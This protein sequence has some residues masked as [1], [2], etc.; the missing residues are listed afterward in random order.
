LSRENLFDYLFLLQKSTI[1]YSIMD[2]KRKRDDMPKNDS[3]EQK[4]QKIEK[5]SHFL[6]QTQVGINTDDS[7]THILHFDL[8]ID[9]NRDKPMMI[10]FDDPKGGNVYFDSTFSFFDVFDL[11]DDKLLS[12]QPK[13][14]N[15]TLYYTISEKEKEEEELS[16][17]LKKI[18]NFNKFDVS[19]YTKET[20]LLLP[21]PLIRSAI[22]EYMK[23]FN[24]KSVLLLS[25]GAGNYIL[26]TPKK[27]QGKI[28]G[29]NIEELNQKEDEPEREKLN[30]KEKNKSHLLNDLKA[31]ETP[32][33]ILE[34][35]LEVL[36]MDT[37]MALVN[38]ELSDRVM[39][40][41]V[42]KNIKDAISSRYRI[43]SDT[44]LFTLISHTLEY[45]AHHQAKSRG[46]FVAN[47]IYEDEDKFKAIQYH[48]NKFS[49][50]ELKDFTLYATYG[51]EDVDE[52][53]RLGDTNIKNIFAYINKVISESELNKPLSY[54]VQNKELFKEMVGRK[55]NIEDVV[56]FDP[57]IGSGKGMIEAFEKVGLE[58][59]FKFYG[60]DL[61]KTL[62]VPDKY[63][64]KMAIIGGINTATMYSQLENINFAKTNH[65]ATGTMNVFTNPPFSNDDDIAKKTLDL[66]RNN[67]VISGV[68][69]LKMR[70]YIKSTMGQDS[71]IVEIP[72]HLSGYTDDSV[73]ERLLFFMGKKYSAKAKAKED[74]DILSDNLFAD[75]ST[76]GGMITEASLPNDATHEML[77]EALLKH[78]S[79]K[80]HY[81]G[82]KTLH[83]GEYFMNRDFKKENLILK[84][85][86]KVRDSME[87]LFQNASKF[88]A[89]IQ[90]ENTLKEFE[91]KVQP[92]E[93]AKN[94][95]VFLDTRYFSEKGDYN[96]LSF[97]EVVGDA[98]LLIHYAK[99]S[100]R[101]LDI[102]EVVA[103][104]KKVTLPID[105]NTINTEKFK[106][107]Q[108][109]SGE[110]D[111]VATDKLGLM[112]FAYYPT[113][114]DGRDKQ[115]R[116]NL[117]KVIQS[118]Y[119]DKGRTVTQE[120]LD[121]VDKAL[122]NSNS[123]SIR[124]LKGVSIDSE[125]DSNM[126]ESKQILV[127]DG[128]DF[129]LPLNIY[130]FDFY[131]KLEEFNFLDIKDYIEIAELSDE[132]KKEIINGFVDYATNVTAK[133]IARY[134]EEELGKEPQSPNELL[135]EMY[136][137]FLERKRTV[138]YEKEDNGGYRLDG[139]GEKIEQERGLADFIKE[140]NI[141]FG[142]SDYVD[143]F[144]E[145]TNKMYLEYTL[146]PLLEKHIPQYY[147]DS[148]KGEERL[149]RTIEMMT[150][151]FEKEPSVFFKS[152]LSAFLDRLVTEFI[153]PELGVT[154][155]SQ[156]YRNI[157]DG[158]IDFEEEYRRNITEFQKFVE[159]NS[160][161]SQ[162][163]GST[164]LITLPKIKIAKNKMAKFF[165]EKQNIDLD[166]LD[167]ETYTTLENQYHGK[168]VYK[169]FDQWTSQVASLMPH[170]INE[171]QN[172]SEMKD[173]KVNFMLKKMRTG[174]T[175][176]FVYSSILEMFI[177][178]RNADMFLGVGNIK[179]IAS[180]MI[181]HFPIVL[182]SI[183]VYAKDDKHQLKT[184]YGYDSIYHTRAVFNPLVTKNLGDFILGGGNTA[185]ALGDSF[186]KEVEQ[187][188]EALDKKYPNGVTFEDM[189]NDY[190]DSP[191]IGLIKKAQNL[192]GKEA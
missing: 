54:I 30:Q 75:Y 160:N 9:E 189:L 121:G 120:E 131:Q 101:I 109:F 81:L 169:Y 80:T 96:A 88:N 165:K 14:L 16:L 23:T 4:S 125:T 113:D 174:K 144:F 163:L 65:K 43:S 154:Q 159:E 185:Q 31:Y 127:I 180:Q 118:I 139:N 184:K 161:A 100:P 182:P 67:T 124:S 156:E 141:E 188:D 33:V 8:T 150:H 158:R 104:E 56:L 36:Q 25:R 1:G 74:G 20:L 7:K 107:G 29:K 58:N 66:F 145:R 142:I 5:F 19:E 170:Q 167:E 130:N 57:Q 164:L 152:P 115:S 72:K 157:V 47:S 41:S 10:N 85:L 149:V 111:K 52:E 87:K 129:S 38:T 123:V 179:D 11:S 48:R 105:R 79:F 46:H 6:K 176:T 93:M 50:E 183:A 146:A 108:R 77:K 122:R 192:C 84:D 27:F 155:E 42:R 138:V 44:E 116:Q 132:R 190:A 2:T 69:P 172:F 24:L 55:L 99:T 175:L 35:Y 39:A 51:E 91:K 133:D 102:I 168:M 151:Y 89:L 134:R 40:L 76:G 166:T 3:N 70:N 92:L 22:R 135:R 83:A 98:T 106:I 82:V 181:Q 177:N 17:E 32:S 140:T 110:K 94:E 64:D 126:I 162:R 117:L 53:Y 62:E 86:E 73:P 15:T 78:L 148:E 37:F 60:S 68:L 186:S 71:I 12:S 103:K 136:L 143:S 137:Y 187:I 90:S 13:T 128:D 63:Q 171:P 18:S 26:P 114:F 119:Q 178:K 191:F 61:R 95:K 147:L 97:N 112:K 49:L 45:Y 34:S 28:A 21:N 59:H 153:A 173:K